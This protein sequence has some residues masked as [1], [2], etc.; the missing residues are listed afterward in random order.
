MQPY[1]FAVLF[2]NALIEIAICANKPLPFLAF[3]PT[4]TSYV[5][6]ESKQ[7]V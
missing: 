3:F 2:T 4:L 7:M 5:S 1:A 6:S